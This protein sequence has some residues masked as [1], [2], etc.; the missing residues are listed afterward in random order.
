[1]AIC[2]KVTTCSLPPCGSLLKRQQPDRTARDSHKTEW[3]SQGPPAFQRWGW[4]AVPD[5]PHPK[6]QRVSESGQRTQV[7]KAG[8]TLQGRAKWT[9]N[10]HLLPIGLSQAA[11]RSH[12]KAINPRSE[13]V[14][15]SKGELRDAS[16]NGCPDPP[17]KILTLG[18]P[19]PAR[20]PENP[21]TGKPILAYAAREVSL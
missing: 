2:T 6:A 21:L 7:G 10:A 15:S 14:P 17:W 20:S 19:P 18:D 16:E 13:M 11:P 8:P 12:P 4:D 9:T 5:P 1:M 3:L